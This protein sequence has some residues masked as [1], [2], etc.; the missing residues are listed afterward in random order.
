MGLIIS[1]LAIFHVQYVHYKRGEISDELENMETPTTVEEAH[2]IV[3]RY[4]YQYFPFLGVK[5]LEFGLFKTYGKP[6]EIPN[7]EPF[8]RSCIVFTF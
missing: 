2:D 7:T 5:A 8:P 4:Y 3:L 1:A 6:C